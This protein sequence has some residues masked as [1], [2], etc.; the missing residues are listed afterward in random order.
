MLIVYGI[1][2]LIVGFIAGVFF[3]LKPTSMVDAVLEQR[4]AAARDSGSLEEIQRVFDQ[5]GPARALEY[6]SRYNRAAYGA[7]MDSQKKP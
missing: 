2:I 4:Q 1:V 3:A 7:L 6:F 5:A